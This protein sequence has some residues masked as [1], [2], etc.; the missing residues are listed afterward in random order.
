[1]AAR[2]ALAVEA[3]GASAPCSSARFLGGRSGENGG[4]LKPKKRPFTTPSLAAIG[5]QARSICPDADAGRTYPRSPPSTERCRSRCGAK[6][7]FDW[8]PT[9]P[10]RMHVQAS[11]SVACR[12]G[13]VSI[14]VCSVSHT[15]MRKAFARWKAPTTVRPSQ[16]VFNIRR[17]NSKIGSAV[18]STTPCLPDAGK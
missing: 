6:L 13:P 18:P 10:V 7:M 8:S 2:R 4:M 17:R 16:E 3:H 12:H 1:M 9:G 5:L 15:T 14:T 11:L